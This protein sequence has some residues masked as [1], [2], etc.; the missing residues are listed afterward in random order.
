MKRE[1]GSY[2]GARRSV[3]RKAYKQLIEMAGR[4]LTWP[5]YWMQH[6]DRHR[7]NNTRVHG[8]KRHVAKSKSYASNGAREVARRLR[9]M[10]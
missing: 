8:I 5:D 1:A 10:K 9:R 2:R 3:A 4:I 7:I 6:G